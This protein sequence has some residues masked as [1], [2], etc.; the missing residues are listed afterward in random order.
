MHPTRKRKPIHHTL[1]FIDD[2]TGHIA[3]D[4]KEENSAQE[5][6]ECVKNAQPSAQM[7]YNPT[8]FNGGLV[9]L[10]KTNW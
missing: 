1:I 4:D 5:L 3:G 6:D 9:A 2:Q 7:W 10:H 8:R